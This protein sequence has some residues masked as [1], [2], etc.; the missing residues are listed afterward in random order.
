LKQIG[1]KASQRPGPAAP[2]PRRRPRCDQ[3]GRGVP[4]DQPLRSPGS[5]P[6]SPGHPAVGRA[7]G[8]R[9]RLPADQT[10]RRNGQRRTRPSRTTRSCLKMGSGARSY[11]RGVALR[12]AAEGFWE[13]GLQ[14]WQRWGKSQEGGKMV[15]H[16]WQ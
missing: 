2:A 15:C 10:A 12:P 8:G 1:V 16:R 11:R 9:H 7:G 13:R 4:A 6:A 3:P 5:A 14:S